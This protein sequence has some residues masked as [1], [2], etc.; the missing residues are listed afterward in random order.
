MDNSRNL[1]NELT[2]TR[3]RGAQC[4]PK[5]VCRTIY[6]MSIVRVR[7]TVIGKHYRMNRWTISSIMSRLENAN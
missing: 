2:M 7:K 6:E 3:K 4:I 1:K 5:D